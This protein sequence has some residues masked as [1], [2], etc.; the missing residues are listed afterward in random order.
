MKERETKKIYDSISNV[1]SVFIEKAQTKEISRVPMWKKWGALAACLVLVCA[2]VV[3]FFPRENGGEIGTPGI[4]DA[5]PMIYINN[6]LYQQ[7]TNQASYSEKKPEFV[8]L[9]KIESD[10]TNVQNTTTDGIPKE[11]FQANLPI[12]GAEVYQYGDDIVVEMNDKYWLF[13]DTFSYAENTYEYIGTALSIGDISLELSATNTNIQMIENAVWTNT[14]KI[15]VSAE[16]SGDTQVEVFL[17]NV[18]DT[19]NFIQTIILSKN[20]SEGDFTNLTSAAD[21]VIG[22]TL[23][24]TGEDVIL[25][26][27][28]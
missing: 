28:D 10:I 5:P 4:A 16:I 14:K 19:D 9:G 1:D 11:N 27:S 18:E 26:I 15:A 7:S 25:N 8:L 24:N 23:K 21:Y 22:A 17:Y 13:V 20:K 2:A 12:V 3:Y 6:T